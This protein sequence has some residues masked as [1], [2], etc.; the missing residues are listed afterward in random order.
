MGEE[1]SLLLDVV[2]KKRHHLEG[3]HI[4]PARPSGKELEL[5]IAC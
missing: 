4:S 3:S 2:V 1:R 5:L